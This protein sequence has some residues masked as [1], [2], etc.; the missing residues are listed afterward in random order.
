MI[1]IWALD[2]ELRLGFFGE[3]NP[4]GRVDEDQFEEFGLAVHSAF[5]KLLTREGEEKKMSAGEF[6]SGAL[7]RKE[8]KDIQLTFVPHPSCRSACEH[9]TRKNVTKA[10]I[11]AE[12]AEEG[13]EVVN[14]QKENYYV[15]NAKRA[16]RYLVL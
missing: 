10:K 2:A 4:F 12:G 3:I 1:L 8:T 13:Y 9:I 14:L 7:G 11:V 6:Y 5:H 16:S 15:R